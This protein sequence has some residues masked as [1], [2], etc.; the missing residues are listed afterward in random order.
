[1]ELEIMSYFRTGDQLGNLNQNIAPT[2][3]KMDCQ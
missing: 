3:T 2:I 1:M